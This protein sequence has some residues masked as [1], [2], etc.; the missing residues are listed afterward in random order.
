MDS[1]RFLYIKKTSENVAQKFNSFQFILPR[2]YNSSMNLLYLVLNLLS[3]PNQLLISPQTYSTFLNFCLIFLMLTL[4]KILIP[5]PAFKNSIHFSR[6]SQKPPLHIQ[7]LHI[8]MILYGTLLMYLPWYSLFCIVNVV[9]CE[10]V[11][12]MITGTP[13]T[14]VET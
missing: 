1:V 7:I 2:K 6:S 13:A 3:A 12:I 14:R 8:P 4:S 5:Q 11:V 10:F 9:I